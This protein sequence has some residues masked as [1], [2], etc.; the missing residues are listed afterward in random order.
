MT[1]DVL[2]RKLAS[3]DARERLEAARFLAENA[4]TSHAGQIEAA[5][6]FETVGWVP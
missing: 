2:S 3:T 1:P 6:G 5:L 4:Q